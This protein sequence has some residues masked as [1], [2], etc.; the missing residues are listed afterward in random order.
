M[1]FFQ[2]VFDQEFQGYMVLGDRKLIPTFKVLPNRNAQYKQVSWNPGPYDLSS[3]SELTFN[4]CWGPDFLNWTSVAI[5]VAGADPSATS[6]GEVAG[7]LN[8]D[9][10]FSSMF[11]ASVSNMGSG[12]SVLVS[13]SQDRKQS[14]K[15]YFG[16]GGAEM[17]LG[18][19]RKSGV[20]DI[21]EYFGRHTIENRSNFPDSLGILIRL[22][23]SD[24]ADLLVIESAGLSPV[25]LEDWEALRGRSGIFEFRKMSVDGSDRVTEM[26]EYS[27]GARAGDLA[28]KTT[29]SYSGGNKNPSKVTEVPYIL[30]D[31]DLVSP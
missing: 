19:N 31:S 15:M 22:D 12:D 18:F 25:P 5:D 29:Y 27:A 8:S 6:A 7:R 30:Q 24:P 2:N 4:F 26:V 10:V 1:A 16:N 17:A 3:G 20:A 13:K 23:P 28:R 21:P 11:V 9:P 14:V